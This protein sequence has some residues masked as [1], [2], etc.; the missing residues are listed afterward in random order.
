MSLWWLC[1]RRSGEIKVVIVEATSL[2]F[3]RM[4]V[5]L[6]RADEDAAFVEGHELDEVYSA[7][8]PARYIGSMLP[9]RS[10]ATL[11]DR[12]ERETKR[13]APQDKRR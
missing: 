5:S 11:L 2:I 8:V 4:H 7:L 6:A 1:Y 13:A 9:R 3:A 10:A 12:L